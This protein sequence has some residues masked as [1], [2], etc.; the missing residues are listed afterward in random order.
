[1]F[2]LV[3]NIDFEIAGII[4]AILLYLETRVHYPRQT[5]KNRAFRAMALLVIVTDAFDLASAFTNTYGAHIPRALNLFVN[6]GYFMSGLVLCYMLHRYIQVAFIPPEGKSVFLKINRYILIFIELSF[7]PNVL[8]GFYFE[9]S[10][11]GDYLH[12]PLYLVQHLVSC[13]F[14]LC[15]SATLI[16]NHRLMK[17]DR[18]VSGFLFVLLYYVAVILQTFV[19]PDILIIMPTVSIMLLIAAFSLESPDYIQLQTTLH[20]LSQTQRELEAANEKLQNLAYIDLMTGLKN[21]TAYNIRI[22]QLGVAV[23]EGETIFLIA[24]INGLKELNDHFGHLIG[25]DAIV[26]TAKLLED[27]FGERCACYRIGGDEFAVIA[28]GLPEAAFQACIARFRSGVSE[29][30]KG[31]PYPFSVSLGYQTADRKT[32]LDAQRAADQN[33]YMDKMTQKMRY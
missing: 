3:Y 10:P 5:N 2:D 21:R 20:E 11:G 28:V 16:A 12:G 9:I 15:A 27:A 25:D 14:V 31:V 13:W 33:M 17:R 6:S 26:R 30:Q 7:I 4:F 18:V 1:M 8:W 19:L 32:L 24:D 22:E 23:D 29:V